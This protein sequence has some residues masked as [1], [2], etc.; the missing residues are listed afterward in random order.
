M[1]GHQEYYLAND[2]PQCGEKDEYGAWK[3][4][5]QGSTEWGHNFMC[6]SEACGKRLGIRIRNKMFLPESDSSNLQY[7]PWELLDEE[8]ISNLRIRIKQL[9]HQLKGKD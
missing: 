8:R 9:E 2:C 5:R 7:A 4:A 3:G 6:C 1:S